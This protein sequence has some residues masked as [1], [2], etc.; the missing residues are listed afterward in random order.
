LRRPSKSLSVGSAAKHGSV[1]RFFQ[2][3][4]GNALLRVIFAFFDATNAC[5]TSPPAAHS[6]VSE[7][8][9]RHSV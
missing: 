9:F 5:Q 8:A 7:V 3:K 1:A 4:V 6:S 2:A